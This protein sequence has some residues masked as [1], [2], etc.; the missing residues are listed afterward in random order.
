ML[1]RLT[2]T[3][4]FC[5][6][7]LGTGPEQAQCGAAQAAKHR[8]HHGG[9]VVF[10]A[11][12]SPRLRLATTGS[13]DLQSI[14]QKTD[15]ERFSDTIWTT[16]GSFEGVQSAVMDSI[17]LVGTEVSQPKLCVLCRSLP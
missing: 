17:A 8:G 16:Q 11:E 5:S 13:M 6:Y 12:L 2:S 15:T 3:L 14:G 4:L 9:G 7:L 10:R 1:R